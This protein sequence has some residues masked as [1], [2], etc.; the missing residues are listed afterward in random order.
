MAHVV[1]NAATINCTGMFVVVVFLTNIHHLIAI[2]VLQ[3][4]LL[5]D[6]IRLPSEPVSITYT[7]VDGKTRRGPI[8]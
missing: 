1:Q 2:T 5:E 8:A 7:R 4:S 6:F 3:I